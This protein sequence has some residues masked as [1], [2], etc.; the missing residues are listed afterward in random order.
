MEPLVSAKGVP[1]LPNEGEGSPAPPSRRLPLIVYALEV[2][3]V[4]AGLQLL[5][6]MVRNTVVEHILIAELLVR[7]AA[8]L[9]NLL[10]PQVGAIGNGRFL[11]APGGGLQIVSACT[12]TETYF[13]LTAA[14]VV[15]PL[16]SR[17]RVCGVVLG[18]IFVYALNEV[19]ILALFYAYRSGPVL[20]D[21]LH[22]IFI[23]IALILL[24]CL[25]F[26]W[27]TASHADS[28]DAFATPG[29]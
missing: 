9:V 14:L 16:A 7:P 27:W 19:R 23:P 20:F 28:T 17:K 4:F 12:G 15:F 10:T 13:L 3:S 18:L 5:W 6:E 11:T 25:F 24:I 21:Y 26:L 1:Y 8:V 29:R 2:F 22:G